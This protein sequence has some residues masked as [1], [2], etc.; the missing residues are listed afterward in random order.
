LNRVNIRIKII[1]IIV[2]KLKSG[3]D[4]WLGLVHK[5]GWPLTWVNIRIKMIIIII[6]K[7]ESGVDPW[8]DLGHGLG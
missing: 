6:L 4:L 1:F 5:L 3:V 8:S 2:L 7:L